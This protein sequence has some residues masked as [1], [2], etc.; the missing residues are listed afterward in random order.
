MISMHRPM[1]LP[2]NTV[3]FIIESVNSQIW[4]SNYTLINVLLQLHN[5][6]AEFHIIYIKR[7][8]NEKVEGPIPWI[9]PLVVI[10]KGDGAVHLCVDM[11]M[12]NHSYNRRPYTCNEWCKSVFQIRLMVWISPAFLCRRKQII[13]TFATH[14]GLHQF[15]H[16][17]FGTNSA[18]ELFQKL[19]Q[20]QIH[21]IQGVINIS[22]D[23]IIYG[24]SQKDDTALH[25]VC[26][27]FAE[28]G[29]TLNK[30][31]CLFNQ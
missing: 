26:Y 21:D 11:R 4:G 14:K 28:V 2:R 5:Q 30:E 10:P 15:T 27:C 23:V 17:N 7:W 1:K 16:L 25:A 18:S 3:V 29:L 12:P 24:K 31:K 20:D 9:S 6:H 8:N 19:I 13:T 22:D